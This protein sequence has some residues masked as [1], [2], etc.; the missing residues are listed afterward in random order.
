MMI[1]KQGIVSWYS[2]SIVRTGFALDKTVL[3]LSI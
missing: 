3:T 2:R 1:G